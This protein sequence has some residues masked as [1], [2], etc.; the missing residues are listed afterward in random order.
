MAFQFCLAAHIVSPYTHEKVIRNAYTQARQLV[1]HRTLKLLL[2]IRANILSY[3]STWGRLVLEL[4]LSE[5][6]LR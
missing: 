3:Q 5:V 1:L 4:S 2:H 6:W